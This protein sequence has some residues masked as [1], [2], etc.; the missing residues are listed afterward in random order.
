MIKSDLFTRLPAE[1]AVLLI[2]F[3]PLWEHKCLSLTHSLLFTICR[4]WNIG[5]VGR[6]NNYSLWLVLATIFPDKSLTQVFKS[7]EAV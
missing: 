5:E 4:A 7:Q 2:F 1:V 3:P 6:D